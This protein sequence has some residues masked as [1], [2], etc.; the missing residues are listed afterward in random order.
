[1]DVN[2]WFEYALIVEA[3]SDKRRQDEPVR[4]D[5]PAESKSDDTDLSGHNGLRNV[6]SDLWGSYIPAK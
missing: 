2:R 5:D 4:E 3:G 6:M 1:M